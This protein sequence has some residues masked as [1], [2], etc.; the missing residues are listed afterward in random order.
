MTFNKLLLWLL[1]IEPPAE[2][3]TLNG[4]E[5]SYR[6]LPPWGVLIPFLAAV[7][8]ASVSLYLR[9]RIDANVL[10][11]LPAICFMVLCR[12]LA[13]FIV[14]LLLFRPVLV[15]EYGGERPRP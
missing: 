1:L 5:P 10:K 13:I 7:I 11:R 2:G 12:T 4:L 14:F 8:V 15:A 6:N 3:T 9:Q